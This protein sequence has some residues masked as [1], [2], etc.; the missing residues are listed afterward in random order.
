MS[1]ERIECTSIWTKTLSNN[2]NDSSL[3]NGNR[4]QLRNAFKTLRKN[5]KP[6]VDQIAAEFPGLTIHDTSHS[7]ALWEVADR[8]LNRCQTSGF[9]LQTPGKIQVSGFSEDWC[10]EPEAFSILP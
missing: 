9:G 5:T 6:L 3:N 2:P 7:D 10:L 4:E 1:L 8:F